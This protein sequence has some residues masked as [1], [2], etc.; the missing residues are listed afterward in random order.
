MVEKFDKVKL[1]HGLMEV[2]YADYQ[3]AKSNSTNMASESRED[4]HGDLS[5]SMTA[6]L[7]TKGN[8]VLGN[9]QSTFFSLCSCSSFFLG[10]KHFYFVNSLL[11]SRNKNSFLSDLQKMV[12]HIAAVCY[13]KQPGVQR[14]FKGG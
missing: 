1:N 10:A 9:L 5:I 12:E 8:L 14:F 7:D 2:G 3:I 13:R 11:C 6:T 4:E